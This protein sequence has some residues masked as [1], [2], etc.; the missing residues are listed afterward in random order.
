[1]EDTAPLYI[2]I[3]LFIKKSA[4]SS[5][6]NQ[7]ITGLRKLFTSSPLNPG[8]VI[9]QFF[10]VVMHK[11]GIRC[12]EQCKAYMVYR[13]ANHRHFLTFQSKID[14]TKMKKY[15]FRF[16]WGWFPMLGQ[17]ASKCCYLFQTGKSSYNK[18]MYQN[19]NSEQNKRYTIISTKMSIAFVLDIISPNYPQKIWWDAY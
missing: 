14:Q 1:M 15:V 9:F 2:I 13:Q 3:S 17:W 4:G 6:G 10:S 8:R 11:T 12:S 18:R 7:Y 16:Q 5:V 19:K